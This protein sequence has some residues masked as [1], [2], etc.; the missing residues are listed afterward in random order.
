MMNKLKNSVALAAVG[1]LLVACG[2]TERVV[3]KTE[4]RVPQ[5]FHPSPP[6]QV[7]ALD[8][9]WIVVNR[10]ELKELVAEAEEKGDKL[11]LLALTPQ[12]YQNLSLTIQELK[13]YILQQREIILYYK[14]T[15]DDLKKNV[16]ES[17]KSADDNEDN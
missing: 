2:S 4:Y 11:P 3:T 7:E 6:P 14:R 15:Y 5:I 13:R 9:D 10:E 1:F 16:E 17:N 12:G 8:V